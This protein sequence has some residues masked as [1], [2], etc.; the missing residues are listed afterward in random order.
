M[1]NFWV[2]VRVELLKYCYFCDAKN[3]DINFIVTIF[4]HAH[5]N[6]F[7]QSA[8]STLISMGL[9][10]HAMTFLLRAASFTDVL[11]ISPYRPLKCKLFVVLE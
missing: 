11:S 1:S 4:I 10:N 9:V 8:S 3:V 2:L 5:L 7:A 6:A